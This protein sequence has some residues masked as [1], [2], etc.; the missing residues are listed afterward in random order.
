MTD[1]IE[2]FIVERLM[3]AL[4]RAAGTDGA[5]QILTQPPAPVDIPRAPEP[6]DQHPLNGQMVRATYTRVVTGRLLDEGPA[7]AALRLVD[8]LGETV[9][10]VDG[11]RW[12]IEAS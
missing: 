10:Y 12:S 4:E 9:C 8:D 11:R 7:G 1:R 6:V 5:G 2:R 3:P